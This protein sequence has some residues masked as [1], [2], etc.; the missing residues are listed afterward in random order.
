M[1]AGASVGVLTAFSHSRQISTGDLQRLILQAIPKATHVTKDVLH[2][3]SSWRYSYGQELRKAEE[4]ERESR[5]KIVLQLLSL[6]AA[7]DLTAGQLSELLQGAVQHGVLAVA[8]AF[9]AL[10]AAQ[11]LSEDQIEQLLEG[12]LLQNVRQYVEGR[13][14]QRQRQLLKL[15]LRQP[16]A[17]KLDA[18]ALS[19]LLLQYGALNAAAV[20]TFDM[21]SSSNCVAAV[22]EGVEFTFEFVQALLDAGVVTQLDAAGVAVMLAAAIEA[23]K[24]G[25][26]HAEDYER[27]QQQVVETLLSAAPAAAQMSAAQVRKLLS[28]CAQHQSCAAFELLLEHP[29]APPKGDEQVQM[30]SAMFRAEPNRWGC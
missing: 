21:L 25:D 28:V 12:C 10:P 16:A 20:N 15:L 14:G 2:P 17:A 4:A 22:K 1:P 26:L 19:R 27:V 9:L 30:Y 29:A 11:Q 5:G 24:Y 7:Q 6:P 3:N 23:T 18:E 13:D 8:E